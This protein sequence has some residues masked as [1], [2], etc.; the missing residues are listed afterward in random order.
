[1]PT[2]DTVLQRALLM[3]DQRTVY[4]AGN[5]GTDPRAPSPVQMLDVGRQWPHLPA[6]EQRELEPVARAAGLDVHD[7]TLVVATCDCS[8]FVCWALGMPRG[9]QSNGVIEWINTDSIHAD[10]M[11]PG[12]RFRRTA[13]A[14]VGGLVVYPKRESNERF[15]HVAIVTEVDERGRASRVIHCSATNFKAPPFDAIQ[16]TPPDAFERQRL[17]IYAWCHD[18]EPAP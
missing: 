18:V 13:Q 7:S 10:A 2:V 11:G 17:S 16:N 12:R 4:W 9:V 1:M 5:G 15:G 14:A 3:L 6:D 8:G